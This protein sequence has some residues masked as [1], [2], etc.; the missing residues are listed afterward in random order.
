MLIRVTCSAIYSNSGVIL[1]SILFLTV[2]RASL[3][4]GKVM[5]TLGLLVY[6]F[7]FSIEYSN[8]AIE[9]LNKIFV[10]QKRIMEAVTKPFEELHADENLN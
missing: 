1:S 6:I 10:M 7:S 8:N 2:D 3:D 9:G 4:L 5:S